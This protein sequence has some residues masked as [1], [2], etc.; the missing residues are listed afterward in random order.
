MGSPNLS[1][2]FGLCTHTSFPNLKLKANIGKNDLKVETSK[3]TQGLN[4]LLPHSHFLFFIGG[5]FSLLVEVD[6]CRKSKSKW[7]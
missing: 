3:E 5:Q 2:F 6:I 7:A 4:F 1:L